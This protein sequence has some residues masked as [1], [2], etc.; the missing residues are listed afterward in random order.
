METSVHSSLIR[1]HYIL[2]LSIHTYYACILTHTCEIMNTC[3]STQSN[4]PTCNIQNEYRSSRVFNPIDQDPIYINS[5]MYRMHY[6]FS[7]YRKYRAQTMLCR[8]QVSTITLHLIELLH[9][10]L[11]TPRTTMCIIACG[12]NIGMFIFRDLAEIIVTRVQ[13]HGVM[14]RNDSFKMHCLHF[15][16]DLN[17]CAI[18]NGIS[19]TNA[20]VCS[21]YSLKIPMITEYALNKYY[22]YMYSVPALTKGRWIMC[23]CKRCRPRPNGPYSWPFDQDLICLGLNK[24]AFYLRIGILYICTL[25]F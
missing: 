16:F 9:V 14:H 3:R 21:Y 13:R 24:V 17:V 25:S 1:I 22:T 7:I 8:S 6:I 18:Y 20:S 2:I 5:N 4:K 23:F 19:I 12:L 15:V 11:Y 10:L